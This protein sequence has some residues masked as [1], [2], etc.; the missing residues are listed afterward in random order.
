MRRGFLAVWGAFLGGALAAQTQSED[1]YDR[2]LR[3]LDVT[4]L[5][6]VLEKEGEGIIKSIAPTTPDTTWIARGTAL[7]APNMTKPA[8]EEAFRAA[9]P[10]EH[11]AA[12]IKFQESPLAQE[13]I[14]REFTARRVLHT[15][16]EF[17]TRRAAFLEIEHSDDA[18]VALMRDLEDANAT[19]ANSTQN[20]TTSLYYLRMGMYH[21]A[22]QVFPE[23][24]VRADTMA[25]FNEAWRQ[26]E[27]FF[28]VFAL[29]AYDGMREE[30][31]RAYIAFCQ[32]DAGRALNGAAFAA[33]GSLHNRLYYALGMMMVREGKMPLL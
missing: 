27:E 23:A 7:F 32:S 25:Q 11:L 13:I 26:N 14:A 31:I 30:D 12:A 17:A 18:R 10:Q 4:A 6:D 21:A 15:P 8:F 20:Y 28:M 24:Q 29:L 19:I 3:A 22:E 1:D 2:L 9:M 33:S 5:Y 16:E